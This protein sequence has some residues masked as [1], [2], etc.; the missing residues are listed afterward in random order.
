[1]LIMLV[2]AF[3]ISWCCYETGPRASH[4]NFGWQVICSMWFVF[5]YMLKTIVTRD[6]ILATDS[7]KRTLNNRGKIYVGLYAVHVMMG[8]YY[9]VRFMVTK[10]FG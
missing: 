8:L 4:G 10:D 1:M 3:G 2:V 9:L 6:V 7:G 5:L